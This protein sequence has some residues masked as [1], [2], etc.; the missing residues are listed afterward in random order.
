MW[1]GMC[2]NGGHAVRIR[3]SRAGM[4]QMI[5][6]FCRYRA[7]TECYFNVVRSGDGNPRPARASTPPSE[8]ASIGSA[9]SYWH[10]ARRP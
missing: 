5:K 10:R 7:V 2:S 8:I 9:R 3:S 6:K 4:Q 1:S